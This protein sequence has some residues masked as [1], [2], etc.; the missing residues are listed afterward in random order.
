VEVSD[1]GNSIA[2]IAKEAAMKA[3]SPIP[4]M[5]RNARDKPRNIGELEMYPRN[6]EKTAEYRSDQL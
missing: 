3:A 6:L 1:S 5:N 2:I 4:S